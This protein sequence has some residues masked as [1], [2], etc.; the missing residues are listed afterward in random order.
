MNTYF[1]LNLTFLTLS[2]L[3]SFLRLATP[4]KKREVP[5][6]RRR[7]E[8]MEPKRDDFTTFNLFWWRANNAIIS[9]VALPH[10]ALISPPTASK[11][12]LMEKPIKFELFIYNNSQNFK[13]QQTFIYILLINY[14]GHNYLWKNDQHYLLDQCRMIVVLIMS[15]QIKQNQTRKLSETL[16]R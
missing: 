12:C 14:Y 6:T 15:T 1:N 16:K 10:V 2:N 9:S 11:I 7:F 4:P 3:C 13:Q 5:R 8:R